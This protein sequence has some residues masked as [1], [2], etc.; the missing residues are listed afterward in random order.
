MKSIIDLPRL[1]DDSGTPFPPVSEALDSPNGLLAWGGD[2][3]P[4]R[5]LNAYRSGIFPWYCEG[6]PILWWSPAPRCVI[7]PEKVHLSRRTRRRYNCSAYQITADSAFTEV[8][9]ACA[10]PRAYDASTWISGDML[11]AYGRLHQLG[12]AHSLEVWEDEI[13]VGGIYGLALGSVFFGE[14]MFSR[15]TDASKIAL[16]ALCRQMQRQGYALLDCQ[17]GNPHLFS[18]GAEEISRTAFEALLKKLTKDSRTAGSWKNLCEFEN[19][20]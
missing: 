7:F 11:D 1:D 20:W 19:R 10:E 14:S 5:L 13:L 8:V 15:R 18:M 12:H 6:Q 17:V 2:L 3:Q 4:Q 9:R 16:V